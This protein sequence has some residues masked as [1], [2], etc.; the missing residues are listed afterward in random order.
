MSHFLASLNRR[1]PA[2]KSLVFGYLLHISKN[3]MDILLKDDK[4]PVLLQRASFSHRKWIQT[5][6]LKLLAFLN[7]ERWQGELVLPPSEY[8]FPRIIL[9]CGWA[10]P[11]QE[12]RLSSMTGETSAIS[13]LNQDCPPSQSPKGIEM[14]LF[15][16]HLFWCKSYKWKKEF[17]SPKHSGKLFDL[18]SCKMG[19]EF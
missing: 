15:L 19:F 8:C 11:T 18:L 17:P 14:Q 6:V 1:G 12:G 7:E 13:L 9:C 10:P 3:K 4:M 16:L 2:R 5:Q